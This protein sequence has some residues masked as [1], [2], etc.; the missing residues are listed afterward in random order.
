MA[1]MSEF[2]L[3]D[4]ES[5]NDPT[6][7]SSLLFD[8][9]ATVHTLSHDICASVPFFLSSSESKSGSPSA[10]GSSPQS[11]PKSVCGNLLLWPLYTA[12]CT[13]L[14]SDAMRAWVASQ[15]SNIAETMGIRQAAPLAQS[16]E[17]T[18]NIDTLEWKDEAFL[19]DSEAPM[20]E[21]GE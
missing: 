2:S 15:L 4:P 8:A 13:W 5:L 16:L 3:S 21:Y 18:L 1:I 10:S 6:A 9:T 20:L 14:V 7:Y 11:P 12:A 19:N 17:L